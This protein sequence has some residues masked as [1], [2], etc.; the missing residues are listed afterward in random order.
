MWSQYRDRCSLRIEVYKNVEL[1]IVWRT[2][3]LMIVLKIISMSQTQ[4]GLHPSTPPRTFIT[5]LSAAIWRTAGPGSFLCTWITLGT[6]EL[7][8]WSGPLPRTPF[9]GALPLPIKSYPSGS[10]TF[11]S[12]ANLRTAGAVR[13]SFLSLSTSITFGGSWEA[14]SIWTPYNT[15]FCTIYYPILLCYGPCEPGCQSW[16]AI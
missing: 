13:I 8:F 16:T 6:M 12:A 9:K 3:V 14:W 15:S 10:F 4:L 5:S 11:L 1:E 7:I 2:E